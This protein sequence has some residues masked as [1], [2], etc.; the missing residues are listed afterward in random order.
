MNIS[1]GFGK[2]LVNIDPTLIDGIGL[3]GLVIGTLVI[4]S[5]AWSKTSFAITLLRIAGPRL[6]V[7]L[8]VIVASMNLLMMVAAL[9][10]WIH[11]SPLAK[12]WNPL[13]PGTCWNS[14][15]NLGFSIGSSGMY[16][17]SLLFKRSQLE[18]AM[19]KTTCSVLGF[20][21][22]C[23]GVPAVDYHHQSADGEERKDWACC[24]YEYWHFV[25]STGQLTVIYI[26]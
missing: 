12:V 15:V 20:H 14:E 22:H 7:S 4:C 1:R 11:C 13:L 24:C 17:K 6:K 2:E 23:V 26:H 3:R 21:R 19:A 16:T 25:S 10:Q 9:V 5:T 18:M 8:W